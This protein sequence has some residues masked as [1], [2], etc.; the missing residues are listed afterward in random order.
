MLYKLWKLNGYLNCPS[1]WYLVR[2][3]V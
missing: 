2:N 3:L 1:S